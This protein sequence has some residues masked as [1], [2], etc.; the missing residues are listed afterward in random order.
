M[1]PADFKADKVQ[2][3]I[4]A[5]TKR[6]IYPV[7]L[8]RMIV[9]GSRRRDSLR[10]RKPISLVK[11]R[12]NVRKLS[13][14]VPGRQPSGGDWTKLNTNESPEASPAAV[15][16]LAALDGDW[17]R[18]YPDPTSE[19]LRE[20]LAER[21]GLE[22]ERVVVGN[23]ADDIINLLIRATCDPG[24]TV[25]TT[26]PAYALYSI[27]ANIQDVAVKA[28][29]LGSNFSLPID[30]L[31]L[32]AGEITFVT[33]PNNPAGTAYPP[34]QVAEL[35][36]A[37][38]NLVAVDEAYAEFADSDCLELLQRFD[39]VC[40]IR[41]F[42]KAYGLAGLRIGYL[43][44]P[45]DLVG[46]LLKIKDSYNVNRAAQIAA[47][48]ALAD[49]EWAEAMWA[50]V[51]RRREW[52]TSALGGLGGLGLRVHPSQANFVLVDFGDASA[53]AVRQGLEERRILVR[54]LEGTPE[55]QNALR[56]TIGTDAEL[57][58][59][60]EAVGECLGAAGDYRR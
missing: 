38:A 46:A 57:K 13:G 56:I 33:S 60:V 26:S 43:L 7:R 14:Y 2:I 18:L 45:P 54:H 21:F 34:E 5:V 48:A 4:F 12:A 39:N 49:G 27:L 52:L 17:L 51:R 55:T 30:A 50:G 37:G 31:K 24:D 23:G 42:S 44:G 25:V 15:R 53:V 40:V 8:R 35:A 41:T 28:V 11:I 19:P 58:R 9:K 16:A 1:L 20:R 10:L 22:V 59:L 36:A 32:A 47:E 6:A 3:G 29:P